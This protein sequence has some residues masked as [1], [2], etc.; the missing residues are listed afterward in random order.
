M[1]EEFEVTPAELAGQ[2][3]ELIGSLVNSRLITVLGDG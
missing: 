1:V 2:V 3:G